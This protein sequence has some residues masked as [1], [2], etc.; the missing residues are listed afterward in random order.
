MKI[1]SVQSLLL[2]KT[3]LD[4][5]IMFCAIRYA[6]TLLADRKRCLLHKNKAV[7]IVNHPEQFE[8]VLPISVYTF[9]SAPE[10][11]ESTTYTYE[12]TLKAHTIW[13]YNY[14]DDQLMD[15]VEKTVNGLV[16]DCY[17]TT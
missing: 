10:V 15:A 14:D 17:V 2:N 11:Q 1:T 3:E 8:K 12:N 9:L 7:E 5:R 13:S 4:Q 6:H 16:G